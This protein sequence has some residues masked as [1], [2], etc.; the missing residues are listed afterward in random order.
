VVDALDDA[1][2]TPG[3]QRGQGVLLREPLRIAPD[4][5]RED[6]R[7]S[8]P[9]SRRAAAR[10]T[11]ALVAAYSSIVPCR[12]SAVGIPTRRPRD[13]ATTGPSEAEQQMLDLPTRCSPG[14][15]RG[16]LRWPGTRSSRAGGTRSAPQNRSRAPTPTGR[17]ATMSG[18]PGYG[19]GVRR[20]RRRGEAAGASGW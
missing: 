7:R 13:P 11:E 14:V 18:R 3:G 16:Q 15:G 5:S 19:V 4:R 12:C 20:L 10:C 9:R 17:P 8:S 6:D 1:V 2:I